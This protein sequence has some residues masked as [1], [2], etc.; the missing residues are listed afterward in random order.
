ME[1]GVFI[2]LFANKRKTQ[3]FE[4]TDELAGAGGRGRDPRSLPGGLRLL[5]REMPL[6]QEPEGLRGFQATSSAW[7]PGTGAHSVPRGAQVSHGAPVGHPQLQGPGSGSGGFVLTAGP[8]ETPGSRSTLQH[9]PQRETD[10]PG[11]RFP[12]ARCRGGS[13]CC[14]WECRFWL[15]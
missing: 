4:V 2:V 8:E 15:R 6:L 12:L 14:S 7:G 10:S 9:G 13:S 5:Q 1:K 3:M 11:C